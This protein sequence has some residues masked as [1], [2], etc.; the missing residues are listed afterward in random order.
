MLKSVDQGD[1]C[2]IS[3]SLVVIT[4]VIVAQNKLYPEQV[5]TQSEADLFMIVK[6]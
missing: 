4:E 5:E 1:M 2:W 6:R 3:V